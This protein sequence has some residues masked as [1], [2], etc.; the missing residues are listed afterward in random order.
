MGTAR[1]IARGR[2]PMSGRYN[3]AAQDI[4]L[5]L[6][7]RELLRCS[8]A[9]GGLWLISR[10][11]A[12]Q[13]PSRLGTV[14]SETNAVVETTNG[15][16]RGYTEHD[17][18]TFKG[19][20][21]GA[22]TAGGARFQPPQKPEAWTGIR[23]A[24]QYGAA[25]PQP[26]G[27]LPDDYEFLFEIYRGPRRM[28]ED[29]L[30]LNVWTPDL[31][32]SR[33]RPVMFWLHGGGFSGGSSFEMPSYDGRNLAERSDVVVV[34]INHRLGPL[35]YLNLAGFGG[36]YRLS[37][38]AGLLDI[39]LALE[40]VR[41]N[42][43]AFGG[44]PNNVTVFGQSGGGAKV[45]FLMSMPSAKGLFHKAIAQSATPMIT[46]V[47]STEFSARHAA[48]VVSALGLNAA[49]IERLHEIPA[50]TLRLTSQS[51]AAKLTTELGAGGV[52]PI[53]DGVAVVDQPFNPTAPAL[54]ADIPMI[55][56]NT[57]NEGASIFNVAREQL[58]AEQMREELE[59]TL[60]S[61]APRT[62]DALRR[63]YPTAKP[64]EIFGHADPD[65]GTLSYRIATVLHAS[66]KAAQKSAPAFVYVFAWKTDIADGRPRA[67]HRSDIA[68]VF[69]NTDRAA[70][71]TGGTERARAMARTMSDTWTAFA[72][73]GNPSHRGI[74]RWPQFDSGSAPTMVFDDRCRVEF[75]RDREAREA[76]SGR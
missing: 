52:G 5:M 28:D 57:L 43:G 56:G 31:T 4:L 10:S 39:V 45:N 38:N 73:T 72:R 51:V 74:P 42:V 2:Q 65:G 14:F 68:F 47:T 41:D 48:G 9:G 66:R 59:R 32:G 22:T 33:R 58:T 61:R 75:D 30:T 16:V 67:F 24:L 7:R 50:D 34:S 26:A 64:M 13:S 44:D 23:N 63:I 12:A 15:K 37:A 29:C 46:N 18:H 36:R 6:T 35:G 11:S 3:C 20:P 69:N 40:W 54:S 70:H 53:A 71:L 25:C 19:I 1:E 62:I 76:F 49:S 21:Y 27:N 60:G 55:I 8:A 17:I